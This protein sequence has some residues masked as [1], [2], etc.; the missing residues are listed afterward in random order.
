MERSFFVLAYDIADDRRRQ[1]V[2]KV[3]ES[4]AERVQESVFE[5][6]LTSAELKRLVSQTTR[7]MKKEEDSLRIYQFC[8]ACRGKMSIFG[9]GSV[10]ASPDVT[11][12]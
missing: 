5:A 1:K 2:A 9:R 3:C 7:R 8:N 4:V 11:I 12:V 10:T 6:Y